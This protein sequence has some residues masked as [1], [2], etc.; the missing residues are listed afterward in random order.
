MIPLAIFE[1]VAALSVLITGI[2]IIV[3]TEEISVAT[4][5]LWLVLLLFFNFITLIVFLIWRK[6]LNR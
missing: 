5:F 6:S 2:V 4:R 1:I 3:K